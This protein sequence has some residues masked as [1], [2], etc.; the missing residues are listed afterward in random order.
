MHRYRVKFEEYYDAEDIVDA[1]Q[2][3]MNEIVNDPTGCI[4]VEVIDA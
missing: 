1:I 2:Q 3:A 4:N